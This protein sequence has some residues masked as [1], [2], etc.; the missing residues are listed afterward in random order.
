ML[1]SFEWYS[2]IPGLKLLPAHV[3]NALIVGILL[4]TLA[5]L[6]N[7]KLRA[8]QGEAVPSANLD[9]PNF[10]GMFYDALLGLMKD[11]LGDHARNFVH[12]IGSL[13]FF[14]LFCNLFGLIPG[15]APPTDNLNTTAACAIV[16]F[17]STHYYGIKT[18][19]FG[20][21]KQFT[22]PFWWLAWLMIPIEIISHLARPVSL[23]LRLF[24]NLMGDHMVFSMFV[25][26]TAGL[27]KFIISSPVFLWLF[28]PVSFLIPIIVI[29]L[30]IFVSFVQT[31]VFI[32]LSM[33]YIAGAIS[34]AH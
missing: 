21:I 28:A 5:V 9:F 26:M 29:L 12:L 20:Y 15:F 1:H 27:A 19:G 30:G 11:V 4:I 14:I 22:G 2:V 31:F 3:A 6:G 17:L 24:G 7:R 34:E 13:A 23:S 33:T 8:V 16:V 25:F 10:F 32:L 18:H